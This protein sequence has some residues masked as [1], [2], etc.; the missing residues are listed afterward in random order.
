MPTIAPVRITALAAPRPVPSRIKV[1]GARVAPTTVPSSAINRDEP[2][3]IAAAI[4]AAVAIVPPAARRRCAGLR[5][6]GGATVERPHGA[7][8]KAA[9]T[10][11]PERI[12][13]VLLSING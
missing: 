9:R 5:R 12:I 7:G 8:T 3:G 2:R 1:G 10:D 4:E 11:Q 6:A 13:D